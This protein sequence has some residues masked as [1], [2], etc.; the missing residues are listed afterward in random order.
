MTLVV[1]LAGPSGSGKSTLARGLISAVGTHRI[2]VLPIDSY[3]HD[4]SH[5][6]PAEREDI[7]FDHPNS[8]DFEL[9]ARHIGVLTGGSAVDCPL[10]DF[11]TH[12]RLSKTETVLPL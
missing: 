3:Y 6:K 7:N 4:L 9:F 12:C 8:I 2:T 11:S 10:Y 1:A 5:L